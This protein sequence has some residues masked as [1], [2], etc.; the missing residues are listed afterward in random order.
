M[1]FPPEFIERVAEAN[2]IVDLISQHTQLKPVGGGMMG[3]CPF[4]DHPEKTPSFSVSEIK[5]VYHCFGCHKKGNIFRFLQEYNGMSFPEAI[6]YLAQRAHISLP[7]VSN[8][9]Q[10]HIDQK[11]LKKRQLLGANRYAVEFFKDQLQ[12]LPDTHPV[13]EYVQRRGL[14]KE[15]LETFQVGYA[16]EQWESLVQYLS[17]KAIPL[18]LAEEAKLIKAR[19]GGKSGY[20]DL[21]RD[22]L[23]FP[24]FNAMG[25]PV[26]FGGRII[27]TGEPKYLNSPETAVFYK[28]KTLYGL[29]ETAKFIRAQDQAIIVEGYMD[30]VSLYQAG[31]Q[32][33]VATMGTALTPDHGK[34][35]SRI[36]KNIIVLFDGDNAGKEAAERSLP[37]LLSAGLHPRGLTLPDNMDPDDFV[38][39]Q[40]ADALTQQISQSKDLLMMVLE[41]WLIGYR[42]EAAE[43]VNLADK[44]RPVFAAVV[45]ARLHQLYVKAVAER[46]RVEESWL[47]RA[48]SS[49]QTNAWPKRNIDVPPNAEQ[50]NEQ[51]TSV[52]EADTEKISLKGMS[53][54]EALLLPLLLK[55]ES[56]WRKF[57]ESDLQQYLGHVGLKK[58]LEITASMYRQ[59]PE[60]FDK[61]TSLLTLKVDQPELLF[62]PDILLEKELADGSFEDSY[63]QN[64]QLVEEEDKL[65]QDCNLRIREQ[66]L[67]TEADKL[68][69]ELKTSKD[70][71]KLQRFMKIQKERMALKVVEN[72]E[73]K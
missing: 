16:P 23:M 48:V 10:Q 66:Y 12:Q 38:R 24:I 37:I 31:I 69:L 11:N 54:A 29:S 9:E 15:V 40:G 55:R 65:L 6:E 70:P 34:I 60:K 58:L 47:S 19:T 8:S 18:P 30:L 44:L 17:N 4:P 25:E 45:D 53:R 14:S 50:K 13:R 59:A 41:M 32:N 68:T 52:S 39:K 62:P 42:G 64:P 73:L 1:R 67:K 35:L 57:L 26:A 22:R 43:K 71:E 21:F 20:F 3:R 33:V 61:L 46:M 7:E 63:R 72:K 2:N 5:Q 51:K 27:N 28:T 56:H 49:Q 36:T